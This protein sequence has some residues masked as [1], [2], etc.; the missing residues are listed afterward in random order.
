MNLEPSSPLKAL[1]AV[2]A[3]IA[4]ATQFGL[5]GPAREPRATADPVLIIVPK[6]VGDANLPACAG[7][8]AGELTSINCTA[9]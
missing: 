5:A 4:L 2:A 6:T 1:A 7:A 8:Q 3:I 9:R